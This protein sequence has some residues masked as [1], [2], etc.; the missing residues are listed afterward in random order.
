M[1]YSNHSDVKLLGDK[2]IWGFAY[3]FN[4]DE[5]SMATVKKPVK[6][7]LVKMKWGDYEF[8]ELKKNGELRKSG[9]VSI[10][11]RDYAD[12]EEEANQEYNRLIQIQIDKLNRLIDA[13]KSDLI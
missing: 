1:V 6:G 11:A 2:V 12:T 4:N 7:K 8:I 13:C 10:H 9:G 5:K 3:K